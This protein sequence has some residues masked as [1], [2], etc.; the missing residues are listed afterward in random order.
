MYRYIN[1]IVVE[2]NNDFIV[3]DVNGVGYFIRASLNTISKVIINQKY[4]V[5]IKM[6]VREDDISLYGFN[7]EEELLF[8]EYLITVSGIGA[9]LAISMLSAEKY[10]NI[11]RYIINS[12]EKNLVKLPS[13]GKKTA[14]RMIVELKDKLEKNF[15]INSNN[16]LDNNILNLEN[17]VDVHSTK[18]EEVKEVLS[19][20]GFNAQEIMK[21]IKDIDMTLE[22]EE[23]IS[24]V[25]KSVI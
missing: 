10:E 22:V 16:I 17:S 14:Q 6:I 9:K 12:D 18:I 25:L 2:K 5:F 1:G 3:I 21:M 24:V 11:A 8:F 13:V 7:D 20:L 4:K 19:H 15:K 23:I